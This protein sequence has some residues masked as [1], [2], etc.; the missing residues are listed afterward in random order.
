VVHRRHDAR[1][2]I[3]KSGREK[4]R[5]TE[6]RA[7]KEGQLVIFH[8]GFKARKAEQEEAEKISG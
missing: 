2:K 1:H 4:K 6:Y 5:S 7:S 3:N 8:V